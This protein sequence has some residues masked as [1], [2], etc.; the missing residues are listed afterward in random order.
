M[1]SREG[2][3][4]GAPCPWPL[5]G[6]HSLQAGRLLFPLHGPG[7]PSARVLGELVFK[8]MD[9]SGVTLPMWE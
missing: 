6:A 4:L 8:A 5:A 3:L 1:H 9:E 2:A 7:K